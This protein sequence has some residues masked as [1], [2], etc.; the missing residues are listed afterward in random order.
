MAR[1]APGEPVHWVERR[2]TITQLADMVGI[3]PAAPVRWIVPRVLA[4][5]LSPAYDL[6]LPGPVLGAGIDRGGALIVACDAGS[7]DL[8]AV[9]GL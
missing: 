2:A 5:T 8:A 1:A 7:L 4:H 6:S 3:E 9:L